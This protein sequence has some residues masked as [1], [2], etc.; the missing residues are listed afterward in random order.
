MKPSLIIALGILV[1]LFIAAINIP[2]DPEERRPGTRLSGSLAEN[3]DTDW[4]FL[5]GRSKIYVE[6]RT[7][8]LIPHSITVNCWVEESVLYVGCRACDTKR[9]PKNVARDNRV[10]LQVEGKLYE[11]TAIRLDDTQRRNILQIPA[12]EPLPDIAVF[13]MDP[14]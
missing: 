7:P 11:R 2:F 8:W 9:W 3:Q 1:L 4:S 6:T 14:Q 5:T 10:R 12:E 13:R